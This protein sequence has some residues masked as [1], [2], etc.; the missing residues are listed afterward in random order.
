[1]VSVGPL[2]CS[3]PAIHRLVRNPAGL[4]YSVVKAKGNT[5]L[6]VIRKG[7]NNTMLNTLVR[8]RVMTGLRRHVCEFLMLYRHV[9]IRTRLSNEIS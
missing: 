4:I 9:R 1:M 8:I 3:Q 7:E 6:G 2:K 5:R